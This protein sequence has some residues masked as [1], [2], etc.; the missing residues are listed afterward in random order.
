MLPAP[1]LV[2]LKE[3]DHIFTVNKSAHFSLMFF[4]QYVENYGVDGTE[5]DKPPRH[6]IFGREV[7]NKS[8]L[9]LADGGAD[10]CF[11]ARRAQVTV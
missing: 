3:P 5:R 8:K 6:F 9:S 10:C 4:C 2:K 11:E 7:N 1:G